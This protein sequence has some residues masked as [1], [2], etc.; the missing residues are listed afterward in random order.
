MDPIREAE[1]KAAKVALLIRELAPTKLNDDKDGLFAKTLVIM[2]SDYP[3]ISPSRPAI[4]A[5]DVLAKLKGDKWVHKR[6][7]RK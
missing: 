1:F 3:L 7:S 4:M 6:T 5:R 2:F